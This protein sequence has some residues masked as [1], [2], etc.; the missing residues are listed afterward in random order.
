MTYAPADEIVIRDIRDGVALWEWPVTVVEDGAR[1]LLV[2]QVPGAVGR[3]PRGY[4]DDVAEL[5]KQ[6]LSSAPD[7]VAL[8]WRGTRTLGIMLADQWW[9]TRLFWNEDGSQFL[10]YYVDFIRPI[11]RDGRFVD[12]LD[13]ELDITIAPNLTWRWKDEDH[14]ADL[15]ERGWLDDEAEAAMEIAKVDALDA[16]ANRRYPFDGSLLNLCPPTSLTPARLPS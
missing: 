6:T 5:R 1:G 10:G 14:L 15:W 4:P 8:R 2:W 9:T 13:L 7:R 12:T 11:A 3:V 16:L